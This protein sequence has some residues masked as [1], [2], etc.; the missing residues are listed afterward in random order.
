SAR[1]TTTR[2]EHPYRSSL[3]EYTKAKNVPNGKTAKQAKIIFPLKYKAPRDRLKL[4][5]KFISSRDRYT[6]DYKINI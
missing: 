2:A 3:F 1:S 5:E 6:H 4:L